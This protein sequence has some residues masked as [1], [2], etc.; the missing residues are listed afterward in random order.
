MIGGWDHLGIS[1]LPKLLQKY[2]LIDFLTCF[3]SEEWHTPVK[4]KFWGL[5]QEYLEKI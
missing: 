1:Y 4:L 3:L 5:L 2:Y